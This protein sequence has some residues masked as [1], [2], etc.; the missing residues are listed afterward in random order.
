METGSKIVEDVK[1]GRYRY[2]GGYISM[3]SGRT[4]GCQGCGWNRKS[5]EFFRDGKQ[6]GD[7]KVWMADDPGERNKS[8]RTLGSEPVHRQNIPN[9]SRSL[10][11]SAR[12][13]SP[14]ETLRNRKSTSS[15]TRGQRD[16]DASAGVRGRPR[17]SAAESS[18]CRE[19]FFAKSNNP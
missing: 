8:G 19:T 18:N 3:E 16:R 14:A 1:Q 11:L 6:N 13:P 17:E 10:A 5:V 9:L 15:T 2:L 12:V 7:E 4:E